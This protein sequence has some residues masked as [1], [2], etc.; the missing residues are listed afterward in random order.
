MKSSSVFSFRL[1]SLSAVCLVVMSVLMSS[2]GKDS[3]QMTKDLD[4]LYDNL[5]FAMPAYQLPQIPDYQV[6]IADFGG[7]NDGTADNTQAFADAVAHIAQKGGGE[8][9]VGPGIWLTGPIEFTSNFCLNVEKGAVILFTRDHSKYPLIRSTFEG[10]DAWRCQSPLSAY[11]CENIAIVGEGVLDGQGDSWRPVKKG[12]MTGSQWQKLL[13]SGGALNRKGDIWFPSEGGRAG[14][15]NG[16]LRSSSDRETLESVKDFFRPVMLSFRHCKNVLLT[17]V[18]F[19]NS[20]AWCLH[21]YCCENV[22]LYR[23]S[24]RNPWYSQNGDGLDLESCTNSIIT[25]CTFDV[26]DDA[27]CIKSGKDAQ[28]RRR[29]MPTQDALIVGNTVYHGHGGFVIGSEMSGGA[30]RLYVKDCTFLGTDVGL[31]FKST[32]GRG[33]VVEDIFIDGIRMVD[34]PTEA[35]SF[36]LYY[37][38]KSPVPEEGDEPDQ[39]KVEMRP[40]DETTPVFR[41]IYISNVICDGADCA[42]LFNGLPEMKISEVEIHNSVFTARR[43]GILAQVDGILLDKVSINPSEGKELLYQDAHNVT[44]K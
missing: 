11:N 12:K 18:S 6:D 41:K 40:V 32:R 13:D 42:F 19:Q 14:Y 33:G 1:G 29:G 30:R 20:P 8:L 43:G 25:Q 36:N 38:G 3:C 22:V 5:P 27:I 21:P 44:V 4:A 9:R 26:G 15:E 37:S 39:V 16:A 10:W 23:V 35:L 31:R 24:V 34:I 28:G 2:C 7:I 17:G